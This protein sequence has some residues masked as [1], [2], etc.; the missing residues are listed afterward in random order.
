MQSVAVA[1]WQIDFGKARKGICRKLRCVA[2]LTTYQSRTIKVNAGCSADLFRFVS[3]FTLAGWYC[4]D[5]PK[6]HINS[7]YSKSRERESHFIV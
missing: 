3:R 1:E 7:V 4:G 2:K 6:S 5:W